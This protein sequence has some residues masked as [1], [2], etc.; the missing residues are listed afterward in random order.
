MSG[1][2]IGACKTAIIAGTLSLIARPEKVLY[3]DLQR[4]S[5]LHIPAKSALKLT[6][7]RFHLPL[8]A[9]MSVNVLPNI[10]IEG[11][12]QPIELGWSSQRLALRDDREDW[13]GITN[14]VARR[15]LQNRLNQRR[16]SQ[17]VH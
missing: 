5:N 6:P 16:R 9:T 2:S 8:Q 15:K 7:M 13:T 11:S 17:Y 12:A 14:P 3:G 4:V 1:D 10:S